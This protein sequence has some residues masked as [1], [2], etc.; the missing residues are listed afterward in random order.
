[1]T[2]LDTDLFLPLRE[3]LT[4]SLVTGTDGYWDVAR[5]A[6]VLNVDQRPSAVVHPHDAADVAA[7]VDFARAHGLRVTAQGTGHNAAPLGDLA[8]TLLVKTSRMRG[9]T[10]DPES[11]TAWVQAGVVWQE[12][13]EAAAAH[14]LA[15][16]LGSSPDVGVVGYTL[17]GGLSWFGRKHGLACNALLAAEVVTAD[18]VV[19]R[20]DA[21]HDPDLFWAL[22]GGGGSFAVVTAVQ[23]RLWPI[24]EVQ[25]GALFWPVEAGAEVWSAW[26]R[27]VDTLPEDTTTWARYIS[28]PPLPMVPE[29][30]RGRQFVV[31]EAC[32]LG[33]ATEADA[34]LAPMRAL[35]PVMDT[36]AT[37]PTT[38]LSRVHMDPEEPVPCAGDGMM[39]ADLPE[40][41]VTEL[42]RVG[43]AGSGSPLLSLEVRHLGGGLAR[44]GDGALDRLHGRF[45]VF[46]VALTPDRASE[47][48]AH[49]HCDVVRQALAPWDAGRAYLNF[50]ERSAPPS[51]FF[52]ADVLARLREVKQR[53]DAEDLVRSNHPV[54]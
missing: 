39:L 37:M 17:G 16:L 11:R 53:Y 12:L 1:M 10:I 38:A 20:V 51:A 21:E 30:M 42:V 9:I 23:V 32:H 26:A 43:G 15:G 18:G 50:A 52:G 41:A 4:G 45:T 49:A 27:W 24:H 25:A 2:V 33:T 13:T 14:G 54:R 3:R 29:P 40:E 35:R 6:W 8:G 22:R 46:G 19:R 7:T 31:V 36:V 5:A 47:R 34:L 44:A 48:A 28:F